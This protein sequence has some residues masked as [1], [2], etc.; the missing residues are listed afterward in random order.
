[1]DCCS[2]C[3]SE[4]NNNTTTTTSCNHTFHKK[5]IN[6]YR[7]HLATDFIRCPLCNNS[8]NVH[9]VHSYI[10]T[11]KSYCLIL[12][13]FSFIISIIIVPLYLTI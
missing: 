7:L 5:C 9:F 13:F 11:L 2:I 4:L 8:I 1:M 6:N 3:L 10:E 12:L